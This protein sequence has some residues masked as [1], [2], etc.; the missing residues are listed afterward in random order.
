MTSN[1]NFQSYLL[2]L[3]QEVLHSITVTMLTN[4][5]KQCSDILLISLQMWFRLIRK[6]AVISQLGLRPSKGALETTLESETDLRYYNAVVLHL[7]V[8][9]YYNII[10]FVNTAPKHEQQ[11]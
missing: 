11:F 9:Y 5:F 7:S 3:K 1:T 6:K 10:Q 8:L 4:T 2:H